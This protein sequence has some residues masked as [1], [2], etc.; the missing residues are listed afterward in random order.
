MRRLLD[1]PFLVILMG[2]AGLA[3]LVP[4]FHAMILRDHVVARGFFYS[5]FIILM[6]VG[7]IAIAPLNFRS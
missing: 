5:G 3:M 4:A 2:L 6:L 1:L 7:M